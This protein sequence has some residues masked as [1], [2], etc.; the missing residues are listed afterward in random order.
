MAVNRASSRFNV[1]LIRGVGRA[2]A[3]PNVALKYQ[4]GTHVFGLGASA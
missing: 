4:A 2:G 1:D 3:V